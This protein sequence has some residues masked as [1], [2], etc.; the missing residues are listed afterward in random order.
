MREREI[1]KE[2]EGRKTT[3]NGWRITTDSANVKGI[4]R[5]YYINN[6]MPIDSTS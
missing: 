2:R 3:N 6:F 1:E 5:K 4:I